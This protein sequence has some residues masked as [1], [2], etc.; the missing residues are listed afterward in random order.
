MGL[1]LM[2]PQAGQELGDQGWGFQGKRQSQ[3]R[4]M[5]WEG[6]GAGGL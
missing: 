2:E 4:A 6:G 5:W 3:L 1:E